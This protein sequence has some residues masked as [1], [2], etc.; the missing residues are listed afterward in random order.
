MENKLIILYFIFK[1]IKFIFKIL[2]YYQYFIINYNYSYFYHFIF[3]FYLYI[4]KNI[5]KNYI[6]YHSRLLF[7]YIYFS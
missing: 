2:K 5:L 1:F 7:I 4:K 6:F 3:T